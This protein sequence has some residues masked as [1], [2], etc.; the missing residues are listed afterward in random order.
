[1]KSEIKTAIILGIV[2]VGG[3]A[4]L[5]LWFM[6]LESETAVI[7]MVQKLPLRALTKV[8]SKWRQI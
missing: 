1:M 2:I 5:S 6:T 8:N 7:K 3:V 4:G